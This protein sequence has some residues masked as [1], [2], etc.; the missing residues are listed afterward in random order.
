MAFT[1]SGFR[2]HFPEFT[3]TVKWPDAQILF[4]SGLASKLLSA[5]Q[6]GS[7]WEQAVELLT[8]HYLVIAVGNL[9]VA[10]GGGLPGSGAATSVVSMKKVGSVTIGY[11]NTST[12]NQ[13]AGWYNQTTY[14]QSLYNLMRMFGAGAIQL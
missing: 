8:A 12:L 2:L 14:G 3:D 1:V 7:V 11:E 5:E 10:N 13:T 4:W 6:F 9:Q